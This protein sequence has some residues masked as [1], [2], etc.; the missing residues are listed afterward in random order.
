MVQWH[1]ESRCG[2]YWMNNMNWQKLSTIVVDHEPWHMRLRKRVEAMRI[3]HS[4]RIVGDFYPITPRTRAI[5]PVTSNST[6]KVV[7]TSSGNWAAGILIQKMQNITVRLFCSH[8]PLVIC[9]CHFRG[10]CKMCWKRNPHS[11]SVV[12][13]RIQIVVSQQAVPADLPCCKVK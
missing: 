6:F 1:Q 8:I 9:M 11:Q 4:H 13:T 2:R 7:I 5:V 3:V 12:R 10:D